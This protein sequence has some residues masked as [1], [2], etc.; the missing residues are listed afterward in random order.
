MS[1]SLQP[2]LFIVLEGIDGAGTT[3]QSAELAK[4]LESKGERAIVTSQPSRG[5]IGRLIRQI[6]KE[7]LQTELPDGQ[8]EAVDPETVALLF[9]ADRLNHLQAEVRPYL[10][11]GTH[12]ICDRYVVSS[13][14]YQGVE[15]EIDFVRRINALALEPDLMFFVKVDP[16]VAM[17][18][19]EDSRL[20]RE[21]FEHLPFQKQ[22]AANYAMELKSYQGCPV[23]EVDGHRPISD[24][25]EAICSAVEAHLKG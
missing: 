4:F 23:H 1:S 17:R 5:P 18:R 9:A 21:R 11:Q 22:V 19:I 2:G 16:E 12:V 6:L 20:E 3:T 25:T 24:V 7:K 14:V 8:S 13:F 10:A 15:V